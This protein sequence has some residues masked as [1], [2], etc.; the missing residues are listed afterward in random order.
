MNDP[1]EEEIAKM[2][3][4]MTPEAR[5]FYSGLSIDEKINLK[6]NYELDWKAELNGYDDG[7]WVPLLTDEGMCD[8]FT[9]TQYGDDKSLCTIQNIPEKDHWTYY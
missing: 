4:E 3:A 7:P 6:G 9:S 1:F 5:K 2:I 8:L